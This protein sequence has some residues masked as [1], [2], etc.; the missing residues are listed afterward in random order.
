MVASGGEE[1]NGD[2]DARLCAINS[3]STHV[4]ARLR[5]GK[6]LIRLSKFLMEASSGK[7]KDGGVWFCSSGGADAGIDIKQ[8]AVGSSSGFGMTEPA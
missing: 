3:S 4:D 2:C 6:G 8:L 7:G 1:A 5:P